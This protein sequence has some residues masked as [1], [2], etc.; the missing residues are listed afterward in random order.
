MVGATVDTARASTVGRVK[1]IAVA[2]VLLLA[3]CATPAE[4]ITARLEAAG[5]PGA[6]AKCMGDR[7]AARLSIGQ[8][9]ELNRV[10]K[11][12]GGEKLTVNR[13]IH[14]LGDAD[15]ALVAKLVE[16]GIGCAF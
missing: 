11:A 12:R 9:A 3:G 8:M 10:V 13:L 5:V 16:T 15:P 6:Q 2:A 4:R 14:R 7:L 1:R